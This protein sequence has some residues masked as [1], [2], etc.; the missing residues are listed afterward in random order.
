MILNG[1]VSQIIIGW[2][3]YRRPKH[4]MKEADSLLDRVMRLLDMPS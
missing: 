2:L 4:L 1:S 3:V